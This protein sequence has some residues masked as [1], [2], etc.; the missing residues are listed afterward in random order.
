MG[1]LK[2]ENEHGDEG[3][4]TIYKI[5]PTKSAKTN[6]NRR[7]LILMGINSRQAMARYRRE[8]RKMYWESRSTMDCS[9]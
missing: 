8:W 2:K 9:A 1:L 7:G 5:H 6:G 4:I 3:H